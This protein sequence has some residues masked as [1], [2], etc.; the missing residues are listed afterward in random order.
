LFTWLV[1]NKLVKKDVLLGEI[2]YRKL[3]HPWVWF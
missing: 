1:I 3:L 2:I